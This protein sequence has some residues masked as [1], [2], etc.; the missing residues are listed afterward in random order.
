MATTQI[1]MILALG[2]AFLLSGCNSAPMPGGNP[3]PEDPA[4]RDE[5]QSDLTN[6][7]RVSDDPAIDP[8]D[9]EPPAEDPIP[10]LV[11]DPEDPQDSDDADTGDGSDEED[12]PAGGG[13][14]GGN[15]P[16]PGDLNGDGVVDRLD[17]QIFV[18][19]FGTVQGDAGFNPA[20]DLDGDGVITLVDFQI[21]IAGIPE[22]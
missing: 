13:S 8:A 15:D 3:V 19:A 1:R 7:E 4:A 9:D 11:D 22:P 5:A 17:F 2:L 6:D 18:D 16:L 12:D 20:L 14:T 21:W 10:S